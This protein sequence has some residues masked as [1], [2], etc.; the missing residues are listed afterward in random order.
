[1]GDEFDGELSVPVAWGVTDPFVCSAS[2]SSLPSAGALSSEGS[3]FSR[4]ALSFFRSSL[5]K[6]ENC[7]SNELAAPSHA[8]TM[9]S[10]MPPR[11][12]VEFARDPNVRI[13]NCWISAPPDLPSG[14]QTTSMAAFPFT[15]KQ[16]GLE[17]A[18]TY[19]IQQALEKTICTTR[20][21]EQ[22]NR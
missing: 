22:A 7:L 3:T 10:S 16:R 19:D 15:C 12:G 14:L 9:T 17:L 21:F 5:A 6:L 18:F 4:A 8:R 1:M 2:T 13:M 11:Y 20:K